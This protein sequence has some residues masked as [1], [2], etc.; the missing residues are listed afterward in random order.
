MSYRVFALLGTSL[1][2]VGLVAVTI[3]MSNR[4]EPVAYVYSE[5][6]DGLP[7][8][9]QVTDF[10][11]TDSTN[12]PFGSEDLLGQVWAAD[13]IFTTCAGICPVMSTNMAGLHQEFSGDDRVHFV[14]FTVDPETDTPEVL[15]AYRQKY[16]SED[17]SWHFLTA[18]EEEMHAL[19]VEGFK[20]GS[21]E[22][23]IFHSSRFILVD[24]RG[25]IRG[26]YEGT[27]AEGVEELRRDIL[28]LLDE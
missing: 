25:Q 19:S 7:V 4:P 6:F 27:E 26:Y 23:P 22:E 28:F 17:S 18:P 5:T 20:V 12:Q 1:S 16:D 9:G 15:D 21:V 8:L 13:F 3:I 2:F 24:G 10:A 11:F 14:S